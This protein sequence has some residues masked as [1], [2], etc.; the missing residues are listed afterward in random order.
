MARNVA[1]SMPLVPDEKYVGMYV[2]TRSF[3][4][5]RVIAFG[6]DARVVLEAAKRK[7]FK[8]PLLFKVPDKDK[9]TTYIYCPVTAS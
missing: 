3:R 7:K 1:E 9:D 2:V 4:D 6:K 5:N 8:K